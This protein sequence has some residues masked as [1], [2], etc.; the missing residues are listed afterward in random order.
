MHNHLGSAA[1]ELDDTGNVISYEEYHPF[2]TTAY[3]AKNNDIKSA[4]KRYRYTGMERDDETGLEYHGARYYLPWLGRWLSCD[5]IGI[6]D[7]VNL[8]RYCNNSPIAKSDKNGKQAS[9]QPNEEEPVQVTPYLTQYSTLQL[10]GNLQLNNPFSSDR[11]A[12]GQLH[13][14]AGARSSFGL[15]VPGLGVN[16][17]GFADTTLTADVD[18]T[19]GTGNVELQTGVILGETSGLH[20][21]SVGSASLQVPVPGQIPLN[22]MVPTLTSSL[23]R[24]SGELFFHGAFQAGSFSLAQYRARAYLSSGAFRGSLDAHTIANIGRLHVEAT[25]TVDESGTPSISSLSATA[26]VDTGL[27]AFSA[28][29]Y[30]YGNADGSLSYSASGDFHILGI[31]S[32]H[33]QG[34]GTASSSGADFAG[35]FSGPGPLY[36]SYIFGDFNLS[37]ET[38]IFARAGILGVTYMPGVDV[39]DPNPPSPGMVALAGKPRAPWTPSGLALGFSLFQYSQGNVSWIS[40]GVIPD[41]SSNIFSNFQFGVT[42]QGHF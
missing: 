11:S 29:G 12:S 19:T 3:Q 22:S 35:T 28:R 42:A 40:A 18:T 26:N 33:V 37:T 30:G 17:T 25:G 2:G 32:L 34:S 41:L 7:G 4:A 20:L 27:V 24:S 10:S 39:S 31:P 38:G 36:T 5:P 8:Y 16:T 13:F 6:K 14:S 9:P 15:S 23:A 1:L 21:T